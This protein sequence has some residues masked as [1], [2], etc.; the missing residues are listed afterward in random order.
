MMRL[1][2]YC[3]GLLDAALQRPVERLG[4]AA[5]EGETATLQP[6]RLFNL[7]AR[8]LDRSSGF[9]APARRRMRIGEFHLVPRLHRLATSGASGVVAW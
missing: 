1:R 4:R 6:D 9:M 5:G 7:L 3:G 8:N 2:P